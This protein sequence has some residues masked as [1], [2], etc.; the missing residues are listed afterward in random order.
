MRI[1]FL[2]ALFVLAATVVTAQDARL[3]SAPSPDDALPLGRLC[4]TH[5]PSDAEAA[6]VEAQVAQWLADHPAPPEAAVSI[7]IAFHVVYKS[8]TGE[9]N[10]PESWLNAQI[11]V[12][13]AAYAGSGYSFYKYSVD[14]YG[15]SGSWFTATNGTS[16]ET[17][18]K[19]AL[20]T[21]P[22][23]LLNFYTNKPSGGTLGWATFPWMYAESDYRHGVVVLYSSLPG[24]ASAPYNLGDTGTHEVGHYLGLYHTFQGGCNNPGDS[25]SD[26]APEASAAFGCPVGRDTC[27]GGGPDPIE[28]FMDY[29]DDA[30]MDRFSAGQSTRMD[31]IVA[32]YK[33]SL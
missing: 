24:G 3:T 28:N 7:P 26:T 17:A 9:G 8:S 5:S 4:T 25:V 27:S 31:Q 19:Q 10:I 33:P 21:N 14:R 1:L 13:N 32:A 11:S 12:L 29:T 2:S 18:M 30:C 20:S 15:S 23:D 22:R 6:G 16:A